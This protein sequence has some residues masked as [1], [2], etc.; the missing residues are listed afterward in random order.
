MKAM[1]T[2]TRRYVLY[3]LRLRVIDCNRKLRKAVEQRDAAKDERREVFAV[4]VAYWSEELEDAT[5]AI[6]DLEAL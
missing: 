2:K 1:T 5:A 3:V 6:T 4:D